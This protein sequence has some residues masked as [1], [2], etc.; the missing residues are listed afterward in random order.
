MTNDLFILRRSS[1][2]LRRP[3]DQTNAFDERVEV[4]RIAA[5]LALETKKSA[6]HNLKYPVIMPQPQR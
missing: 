2:M 1:Q 6:R 4:N 5:A 3:N